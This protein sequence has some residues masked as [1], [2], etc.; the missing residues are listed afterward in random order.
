[1]WR[2]AEAQ[3]LSRRAVLKVLLLIAPEPGRKAYRP[4]LA[5]HQRKYHESMILIDR[6]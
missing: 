2:A 1:M 5:Q 4:F 6:L 3:S